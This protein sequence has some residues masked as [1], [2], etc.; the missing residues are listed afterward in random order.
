VKEKK[1]KEK[2][3]HGNQE[4]TFSGF[5]TFTPLYE[6]GPLPASIIFSGPGLS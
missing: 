2:R 4:Q 3:N 6:Y 5:K 1:G